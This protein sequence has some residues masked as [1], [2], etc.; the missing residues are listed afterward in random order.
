MLMSRW[1]PW[2]TGGKAAGAT[3]RDADCT[4]VEPLAST[5]T[6][7]AVAG[8]RPRTRMRPSPEGRAWK[9]VTRVGSRPELQYTARAESALS[10]WKVMV[11]ESALSGLELTVTAEMT[12]WPLGASVLPAHAPASSNTSGTGEVVR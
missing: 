9:G 6:V 1:T 5:A 3:S 2:S 7:Y 12:G 10:A 11:A 4:V 8:A